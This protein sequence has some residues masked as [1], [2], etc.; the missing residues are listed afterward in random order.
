MNGKLGSLQQRR[1][2]LL[3]KAALQRIALA[4]DI[5]P[6]R[7]PLAL[8]DQGLNALRYVKRHPVLAIGGMGL[9]TV[10][11]A[12]RSLRWLQRGYVV[13]RFVH[14]MRDRLAG[15]GKQRT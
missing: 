4:R 3:A 9:L 11:R 6:W 12:T 10:F 5:T 14:G 7:G 1:E 2:Q 8:A 15:V 13:W